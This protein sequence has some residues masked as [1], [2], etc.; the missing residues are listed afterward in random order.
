MSRFVYRIPPKVL[1]LLHARGQTVEKLAQLARTGRTHAG[2]VLAGVP[3]R[4]G[5]TRRRLALLLTPDE[6]QLLG[7]TSGGQLFPVERPST[8]ILDKFRRITQPNQTPV[9]P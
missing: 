3:G 5:Q 9:E 8:P 1:Q 2:Q 4:G 7:W 6:L